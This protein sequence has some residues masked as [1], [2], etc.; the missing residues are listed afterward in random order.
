[1]CASSKRLLV[2]LDSKKQCL[3]VENHSYAVFV[4]P[5]NIYINLCLISCGKTILRRVL[6]DCG[7]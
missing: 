6:I 7:L 1:M 2:D 5:P 3:F 4:D